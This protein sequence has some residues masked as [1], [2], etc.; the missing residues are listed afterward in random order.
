M[1]KLQ[2]PDDES[3]RLAAVRVALQ[4][5]RPWLRLTGP[6]TLSGKRKMA[7][8]ATRHGAQSSLHM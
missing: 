4:V 6:T 1:P 7:G 8:N 3:R 5:H 2:N